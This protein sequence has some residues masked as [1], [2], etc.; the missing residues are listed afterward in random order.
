MQPGP[1]HPQAGPAILGP[2]NDLRRYTLILLWLVVCL[3]PI[4]I[5]VPGYQLALGRTGTPGTLT[6]VSCE[7]LGKGRHDCRGR[8][9]PDDGGP[10]VMVAAS[11]DSS[12]GDVT[13]ARLTDDGSRALPDGVKG[14]LA[15]SAVPAAGLAGLGFLPYVAAYWW[16]SPR[17]RRRAVAAGVVITAAGAVVMLAGMVAAY[18]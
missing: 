13:H 4:P 5:A 7:A 17:A 9:R 8:F 6:V 10:A 14:V 12:V 16:G 3:A 1:S 2:V 18:S 15:A 11:P